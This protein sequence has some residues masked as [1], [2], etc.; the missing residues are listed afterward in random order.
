MAR[1]GRLV[2]AAQLVGATALADPSVESPDDEQVVAT[3]N[4]EALFRD[5]VR[6][7]EAGDFAEA[8]EKLQQSAALEERA[9]TLINLGSCYEQL[10]R[11]SSAHRAYRRAASVA[12]RAN[13]RRAS[14][15]REF[16]DA[17]ETRLARVGVRGWTPPDAALVIEQHGERVVLA[18]NQPVPVDSGTVRV[19]ASAPGYRS[20]Q[21]SLSVPAEATTIWVEVPPLDPVEEVAPNAEIEDGRT[22]TMAPLPPPFLVQSEP[23]L[24]PPPQQLPQAQE[25]QRSRS[26]PTGAWAL[27]GA[28]AVSLTASLVLAVTAKSLDQKSEN[29]CTPSGCEDNGYD[30]GRQAVRL[31]NAATGFA[32][33]GAVTSAVT[34]GVVWEWRR[35]KRAS[36]GRG[37]HPAVPSSGGYCWGAYLGHR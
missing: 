18:P 24:A 6:L 7:M 10:G 17:L 23:V 36:A 32:I 22:P 8:A 33:A 12:R 37:R 25:P 2:L 35:T 21:T 1:M 26:I 4:A 14:R 29:R 31:G 3:Q 34:V 16:A 19:T 20:W 30:L 9:G 5:A 28:A 13:D 11:L 27:G 15:A